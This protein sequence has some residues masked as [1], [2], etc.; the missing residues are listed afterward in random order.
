MLEWV[1]KDTATVITG[2]H[3]FQKLRKDGEDIK[4]MGRTSSDEKH[5]TV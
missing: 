5:Y 3:I 4:K 2:L 1:D